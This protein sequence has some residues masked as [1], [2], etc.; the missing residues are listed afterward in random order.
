MDVDFPLIRYLVS[1]TCFAILICLSHVWN[2][3]TPEKHEHVL[4]ISPTTIISSNG[5]AL[6]IP[7]DV[8]ENIVD[9]L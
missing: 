5:S 1:C 2:I 4:I 9:E 7:Q 3:E 8:I 6:H